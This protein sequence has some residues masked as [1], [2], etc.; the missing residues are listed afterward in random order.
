MSIV[1]QKSTHR[2]YSSIY[3]HST[4]KTLLEHKNGPLPRGLRRTLF[5]HL[6]ATLPDGWGAAHWQSQDIKEDN[7]REQ[8]LQVTCFKEEVQIK[9]TSAPLWVKFVLK[10]SQDP[11]NHLKMCIDEEKAPINIYTIQTHILIYEIMLLQL[12]TQVRHPFISSRQ[13]SSL[14]IHCVI[15]PSLN[16]SLVAIV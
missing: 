8:W 6:R 11:N 7:A 2:P 14:P 10:V 13:W 16:T 5:T 9:L 3:E 1:S 12:Q 4:L 15:H